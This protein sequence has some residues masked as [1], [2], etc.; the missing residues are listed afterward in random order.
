[1]WEAGLEITWSL[2]RV[3]TDTLSL[4]VKTG[5]QEREW[6]SKAAGTS[7]PR[8]ISIQSMLVTATW[9]VGLERNEPTKKFV[10]MLKLL[11]SLYILRFRSELKVEYAHKWGGGHKNV[12]WDSEPLWWKLLGHPQTNR[13]ARGLEPGM[14]ESS[15]HAALGSLRKAIPGKTGRLLSSLDTR[16]VEG[17]VLVL[18]KTE[19]GGLL[20]PGSSRPVWTRLQSK[21]K[22]GGNRRGEGHASLSCSKCPMQVSFPS[23]RQGRGEEGRDPPLHHPWP[24]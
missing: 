20:E 13:V 4:N 12:V 9:P 6:G 3:G 14:L 17:A 22:G 1:M 7:Q 2:T 21:K 19:A 5:S 16:G 15:D 24:Y 23:A 18:Q 10:G 11:W 8:R